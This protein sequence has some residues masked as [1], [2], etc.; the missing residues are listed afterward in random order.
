MRGSVPL[1]GAVFRGAVFR[2]AVFRTAVFQ[3]YRASGFGGFPD[4]EFP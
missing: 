2:G 1:R 4:R 3:G